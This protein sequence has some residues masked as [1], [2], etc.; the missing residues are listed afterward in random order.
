[1][2]HPQV[3]KQCEQTLRATYSHLT[4]MSGEGDLVDTAKAAEE[5]AKGNLPST[6]AILGPKTLADH[7]HFDIIAKDLQ[8]KKDN[9]TRFLVVARQ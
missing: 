8:D 9:L 6:T 3:F 7:Y 5:L 1:M 4:L 2:A